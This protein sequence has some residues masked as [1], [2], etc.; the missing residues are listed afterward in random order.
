MGAADPECEALTCQPDMLKQLGLDAG[1]G[2][3]LWLLALVRPAIDLVLRRI[4]SPKRCVQACGCK[5]ETPRY[6]PQVGS[7]LH[8]ACFFCMTCGTACFFARGTVFLHNTWNSLHAFLHG[9]ACHVPPKCPPCFFS[10]R[11]PYVGWTSW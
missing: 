11:L 9:F 5:I 4:Q 10:V 2:W 1:Q 7:R 8:T 6:A 3:R